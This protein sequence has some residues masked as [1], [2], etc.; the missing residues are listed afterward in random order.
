[1]IS[2][3]SFRILIELEPVFRLLIRIFTIG[4]CLFLI[5]EYQLL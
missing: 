2:K 1:M 3:Q 5:A 4:L